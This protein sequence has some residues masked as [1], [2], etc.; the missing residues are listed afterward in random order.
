MHAPGDQSRD[1]GRVDEQ[2]R[3]DVVGD[4]SERVEVYE[5]RIRGRSGDDQ[6]RPGLLRQGAYG[7]VVER[8]RLVVDAVGCLL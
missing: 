4:R 8:L 5:P 7:V 2:E 1:V 3:T 6:L